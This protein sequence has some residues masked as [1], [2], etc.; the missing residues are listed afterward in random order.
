MANAVEQVLRTFGPVETENLEISSLLNI[1][2]ESF[3]ALP[4]EVSAAFQRA[5]AHTWFGLSATPAG[6]LFIADSHVFFW[7]LGSKTSARLDLPVDSAVTAVAVGPARPNS[8]PSGSS[9]VFVVATASSVKLVGWDLKNS[10]FIDL[11]G[12]SCEFEHGRYFFESV[13]VSLT[14]VILLVCSLSRKV[15][16]LR[17]SPTSGWFTFS[18][19]SLVEI[20]NSTSVLSSLVSAILP[21]AVSVAAQAGP[22]LV[23]SAPGDWKRA[24]FVQR[25]EITVFEISAYS[26]RYS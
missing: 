7:P 25:E 10:R 24:L 17:Y 15:Y 8:V 13:S 5:R 6:S 21:T 19:C 4:E 11:P 16:Q 1:E 20:S 18:K 26:E 22:V 3:T 9:F 23:G 12:Y 14:G 2:E